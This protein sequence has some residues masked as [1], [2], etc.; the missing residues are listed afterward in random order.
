MDGNGL[1]KHVP[2]RP[3]GTHLGVAAGASAAG[4]VL[5]VLAVLVVG[6]A[7]SMGCTDPCSAG[8]QYQGCFSWGPTLGATA[9]LFLLPFAA[10][11][12]AN[13]ITEL[14]RVGN[15]MGLV[16]VA[17]AGVIGAVLCL[18]LL[19]KPWSAF[20]Y[21]DELDVNKQQMLA[22][23]VLQV[24][25]GG[26][27]FL[28]CLLLSTTALLAFRRG[29]GQHGAGSSDMQQQTNAEPLLSDTLSLQAGFSGSRLRSNNNGAVVST[30]PQLDSTRATW[31]ML[32]LCLLMVILC[33][34]LAPVWNY[35][36]RSYAHGKSP[37]S[38]LQSE[39]WQKGFFNL[40]G[41]NDSG[42]NGGCDNHYILK[43]FPD[44]V[45]FYVWLAA[46]V[47]VGG[48]L[49]R[50]TQ[51]AP[52]S[53]LHRRLRVG[54]ASDWNPYAHGASVGELLLVA[55]VVALYGWWLYYW[56]WS[57]DRIEQESSTAHNLD[58][59]AVCCTELKIPAPSGKHWGAWNQTWSAGG[60]GP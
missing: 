11:A 52:S 36:F 27:I 32:G 7:M 3:A 37:Y 18:V 1:L 8:I 13:L 12:T 2:L 14:G 39:F 47:V 15:Y 50:R 48:A 59:Q 17:L 20:D 33:S 40:C 42:P 6:R 4:W 9:M 56:R 57:Y 38:L 28:V 44:T 60:A 41:H 19:M 5:V 55:C 53:L 54:P 51:H 34:F 46:V 58:P 31:A 16:V 25:L 10:I 45:V 49:V 35:S 22:N 24:L 21:L 30:A 23:D 26:A 43:L 29:R